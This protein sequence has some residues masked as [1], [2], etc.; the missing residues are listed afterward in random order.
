MADSGDEDETGGLF[1]EP[2]GFYQP[3][4]AP[5]IVIHRTLDGRT[6]S[7]RLVGHSPLWVGTAFTV[8]SSGSSLHLTPKEGPSTLECWAHNSRLS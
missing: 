5:A 3:E 8:S 2:E 4:K 7:L 6:L 1:E